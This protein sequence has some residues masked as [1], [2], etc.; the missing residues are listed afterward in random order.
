MS[1]LG[2][3]CPFCENS[4]IINHT[5]TVECMKCKKEFEKSDLGLLS[6]GEIEIDDLFTVR[7][8]LKIFKGLG[9]DEHEQK[10]AFE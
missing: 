6:K 8:K 4:R 5:H 10:Y 7:E 2:Y 3:S 9:Y 1:E